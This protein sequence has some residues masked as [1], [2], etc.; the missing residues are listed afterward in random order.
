LVTPL[1]ALAVQSPGRVSFASPRALDTAAVRS[2]LRAVSCP[3]ATQ[4]TAIMADRLEVTFNPAVTP[5]RRGDRCAPAD[6]DRVPGDAGVRRDR[7]SEQGG[8]AGSPHGRIDDRADPR[9]AGH[10]LRR[11]PNACGVRRGRLDRRVPPRLA[12][13]QAGID[14]KMMSSRFGCPASL[15]AAQPSSNWT[16]IDSGTRPT[17]R[18]GR[19]DRPLRRDEVLRQAGPCGL[20]D[21]L[22]VHDHGASTLV[23]LEAFGDVR[24]DGGHVAA[25]DGVGVLLDLIS[26]LLNRHLAP[27]R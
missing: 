20:S 27:V 6:R 25:H 5:E 16:P 22:G 8:A 11:L 9:R 14:A 26:G 24:H 23:L 10:L 13:R 1:I 15:L 3:A 18:S 19:R 21:G 12:V 4:C 17:D 2:T 7:R